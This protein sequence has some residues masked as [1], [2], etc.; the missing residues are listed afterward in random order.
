M[1]YRIGDCK[2]ILEGGG[3]K[4]TKGPVLHCHNR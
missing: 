3:G 1:A 2:E 4:G